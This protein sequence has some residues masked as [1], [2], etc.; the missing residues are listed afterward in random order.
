MM[1]IIFALQCSS[2]REHRIIPSDRLDNELISACQFLFWLNLTWINQEDSNRT[3]PLSLLLVVFTITGKNLFTRS[4]RYFSD[5]KSAQ[6]ALFSSSF[7]STR[8]RSEKLFFD[9]PGSL[10]PES[11]GSSPSSY[12]QE[13]ARSYFDLLELE[14]HSSSISC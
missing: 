2:G 14:K 3:G 12:R 7:S 11:V 10:E 1:I 4:E 5:R 9:P 8:R 13:T 6:S